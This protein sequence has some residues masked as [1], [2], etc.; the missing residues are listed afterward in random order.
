M[1]LQFH[2]SFYTFAVYSIFHRKQ[3]VL[4]NQ[5]IRCKGSLSDTGHGVGD[6]VPVREVT[7][8]NEEENS[9][10]EYNRNDADTGTGYSRSDDFQ[11]GY[12]QNRGETYSR[13]DY[14]YADY[15]HQKKGPVSFL[16]V[17]LV[18]VLLAGIGVA[19]G[20]SAHE[21]ISRIRGIQPS[22][23]TQV[24]EEIPQIQEPVIS[25]VIPDAPVPEKTDR[26]GGI[27]LTDVSDV[28]EEVMPSVVSVTNTALYTSTGFNF[29]FGFWQ[30]P[31]Q[32]YY[33]DS[34]GSG[35]IVGQNESE[36]LIVTNNHVIED[37]V[38]L[39]VEFSDGATAEAV[40]KGADPSNDIAIISVSLST[41]SDETRNV[42][43]IAALGD[44]NKLR[45][46]QG[47]IAIGNALGYGQSVTEGVVS[48]LH[49]EITTEEG[50][51]LTVLQTSAAINPGNSGGALLNCYGE[52]IGINV[53]KSTANY[54]EGMGFAIPISEVKD[55]MSDM[56]TWQV[57]E[58]VSDD[59]AGYLGIQPFN[60]DTISATAYGMPVG[61]YAYSVESGS[62]AARA[63]M[64]D[65]DIITGLDH[66]SI[67]DISDLQKALSYFRG[68]DTVTVTIWRLIDGSYQ[69]INLE[70]TL[71]YKRDYVE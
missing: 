18:L 62:P 42:I 65:K 55:L 3:H 8:M 68:G 39:T 37:T 28:V 69:Q 24:P 31:Q 7:A 70:I 26:V 52:V 67:T 16:V 19:G 48:A 49:R 53:A 14:A 45:M 63:G 36:L 20:Y 66:Y 12:S 2:H 35:I 11:S 17:T 54:S 33:A 43:R 38:S 61:V 1:F 34:S 64:K 23:E 41:L 29:G 25:P 10:D 13:R 30:T 44:S 60:V 57:R 4:R 32:E 58:K 22:V 21:I 59:E 15:E 47:V 9:M 71:G 56:M 51:T 46:G 27:I 50:T 5:L 6:R 40:V